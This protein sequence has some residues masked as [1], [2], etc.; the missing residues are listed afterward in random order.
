M[1]PLQTEA[2]KFQLE[3]LHK[4][5]KISIS[6]QRVSKVL[7]GF[8]WSMLESHH[9]RGA[10]RSRSRWQGWCLFFEL[11]QNL[12]FQITNIIGLGGQRFLKISK[13]G[14]R[15]QVGSERLN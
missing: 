8:W 1:P 11:L 12:F 14:L 15:E 3:G 6:F 5:A 7:K 13:I 10:R 4:K 9:F 2:G